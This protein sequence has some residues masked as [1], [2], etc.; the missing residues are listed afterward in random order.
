MWFLECVIFFKSLFFYFVGVEGFLSL[1][2]WSLFIIFIFCREGGMKILLIEFSFYAFFVFRGFTRTDF[3]V[4]WEV[5][6]FVGGKL[7]FWGWVLYVGL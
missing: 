4:Y 1:Y 6:V 3:C 2:V 7:R 5:V